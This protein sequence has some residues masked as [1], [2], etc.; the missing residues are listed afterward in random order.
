MPIFKIQLIKDTKLSSQLSNSD[1][2]LLYQLAK[3]YVANKNNVLD[4]NS[5]K[6]YKQ[7]TSTLINDLSKRWNTAVNSKQAQGFWTSITTAL[8]DFFNGIGDALKK[9]F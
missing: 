3:L 4:A 9:L 2:D 6:R 1:I 7:L 5:I 8:G